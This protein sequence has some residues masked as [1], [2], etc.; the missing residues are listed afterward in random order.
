MEQRDGGEKLP[1]LLEI[2]S[3]Q[4]SF[5]EAVL[6]DAY[7][8][9]QYRGRMG[10]FDTRLRKLYSLL[11]LIWNADGF[12][13][14]FLYRSKVLMEVHGIPLLPQLLHRSAMIL[15]QVCI[16]KPVVIAP[17]V[18]LPHGQVVI[19][20]ITEIGAGT[21]IRPWVTIGLKEGV[22]RG[23]SI[24]R[25]VRIGTGAKIL[26]PIRIGDNAIIGANAVVVTDVETNVTVVGV[27]AKPRKGAC[28]VTV[29][30]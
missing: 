2:R 11:S 12:V 15:A 8:E 22:F 30:A 6:A 19:D 25:N 21:V 7:I 28:P 4:P 3:R 24:G 16:G 10:R 1:T 23:P 9:L 29:D 17:G 14:L 5:R 27:P 18:R 13:G 20:G 26:G